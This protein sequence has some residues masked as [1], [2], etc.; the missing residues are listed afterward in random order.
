MALFPGIK[1]LLS[2]HQSLTVLRI[3]SLISS[4]SVSQYLLKRFYSSSTESEQP[5]APENESLLQNLSLMGVDV[6]KARQRQPGV[7]RKVVTNEQGVAQFLNDKGASNKVIA[8]IISRFPRAITRSIEHLETRWALWKNIIQTDAEIV[9]IV[10]RSP[11]AFFRTNDNGNF[12]KNIDFLTSLGLSS[13][14]LHRLLATA[15]RTFSNSV[16]LNKQNLEFLEEIC[17][18]FG[19]KNSENFAKNI[20]SRNPYILIRSTK[21]IRTNIDFLRA[22]LKLSDEES[23]ALFQGR[24]AGILD[25]SNEC[26]KKNATGLQQRLVSLGC[27]KADMKKL[28]M[29]YPGI[30]F[31]GTDTLN[32]KLDCLLKAGITI[33]QILKKPRVL[34]LSVQ[35]IT[36]RLKELNN[37]GYDFQ[38][39]GVTILNISK[40][41]Y[42]EKLKKLGG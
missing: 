3:S 5:A 30:L 33:K 11:E 13:K 4:H 17:V 18:E 15:P 32:S 14:D 16:E 23:L 36:G 29:S 22:T 42:D 26:M 38:S 28:I 20:I 35:N 2:F 37:L 21:R 27:K 10:D 6:T 25:V 24:G 12:K 7:L 39:D 31:M 1:A 9:S 19:G 34:D 8:G 40:K 41:R